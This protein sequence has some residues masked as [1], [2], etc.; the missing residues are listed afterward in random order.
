MTFRYSGKSL[1]EILF[2]G[3]LICFVYIKLLH[4]LCKR[5]AFIIYGFNCLKS[6]HVDNFFLI[7]NAR[8]VRKIISPLN[9]WPSMIFFMLAD[10]IDSVKRPRSGGCFCEWRHG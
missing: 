9:S 6:D 4:A 8:N 3:P 10:H 1:T 5:L 2:T 7:I